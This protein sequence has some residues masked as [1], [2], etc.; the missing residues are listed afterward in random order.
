MFACPLIQLRGLRSGLCKPIRRLNACR[1][2]WQGSARRNSRSA[3][4]WLTLRIEADNFAIENATAS[5]KVSVQSL[6]QAWEAFER[7][8][9]AGDKLHAVAVGTSVATQIRPMMAT[10][11]PANEN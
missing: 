4:V 3:E 6:A 9:I 5:L 2:S 7:V 10:S 1:I 11:K 8:P